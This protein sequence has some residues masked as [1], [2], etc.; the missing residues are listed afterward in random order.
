MEKMCKNHFKL[1]YDVKTEHWYV[2]KAVDELM[3]NR[4]DI[5]EQVTGIMPENKR[6]TLSSCL[7]QEIHRTFES[8]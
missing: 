3:K 7:I 1:D 2:I 5:D 8:W 4:R 6:Q